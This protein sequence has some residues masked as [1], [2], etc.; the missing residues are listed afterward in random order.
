MLSVL[1][2]KFC[3]EW[4]NVTWRSLI[5]AALD[6]SSPMVPDARLRAFAYFSSSFSISVFTRSKSSY[7]ISASPRTTIWPVSL[8][9][10]GMPVI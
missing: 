3:P 7:E 6:I 10:K 9:F 1:D 2:V 4:T 5:S 8:I